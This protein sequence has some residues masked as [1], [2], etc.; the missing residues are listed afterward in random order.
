M[1]KVIVKSLVFLLVFS[2]IYVH[3]AFDL[4]D[5][6]EPYGRQVLIQEIDCSRENGEFMFTDYPKGISK[7]ENIL[8]KPCRV[9]PNNNGGPKYFA[10][11]LGKG[12][13]LTPGKPYILSIEFPDDKP[14]SMFICNWGCETARGFHSG[15]TVG[16][17]IK[18]LYVNHNP[19]SLKIPLS[20]KFQTWSQVFFLHDRFPDIKRPRGLEKRPLLPEDGFWIIIAQ[21]RFENNFESAGA[22]VSKIKL[23]EITD[24]SSLEQKIN[25]PPTELPRR[26][27]FFREEMS[28]GV[29]AQGH[30]ENEKLPE[31]RGINNPINWYEYKLRLMRFLGINTF[32]KD[33]LE[34]GHN[35]GW[36][37]TKYGGND[38]YNQSSTPSLWNDILELIKNKYND[39][40][41]LPYYE[42]A[43]SIG[44]NNNIAIGSQRRCETLRGGK[45]YTHINWCQLTNAD[46]VD[47]DFIEDAKKLLEI[48]IT[49]NKDKVKFIGAWFRPRP[50]ANPISFN[51]KDIEIFNMETGKQISRNDLQNNNG[52]LEEYYNWWFRK[53][54]DFNLALSNYLRKEVNPDAVI[55]YTADSSE[56]GISLPSAVVAKGI[57]NFWEWQTVVVT[58]NTNKW[59]NF[60]NSHQEFFKFVKAI[61]YD[62]VVREDMYLQALLSKPSTWGDYEWHHACPWNDPRNYKEVEG[63]ILTY[64]FNRLYT[65]ASKKALE[66]FKAKS[67]LAIIRHY[68]LNE[69]EMDDNNNPILGYFVADVERAGPYCMI[70]EARA[71]ANGDPRFIGYLSGNSFNRGFPEYVRK[72]NAAFLSLPALPSKIQDNAASDPEVI[73]RIISTPKNG[74]YAGIVNTALV[75]K[76]VSIKLP[77]CKR[78]IDNVSGKNLTLI[79]GKITISMYP[80]ELRS[81]KLE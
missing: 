18:A 33:L 65:V 34:F 28:D 71:F 11:R 70:S 37:S 41:V 6:G 9:L 48:T 56:P 32:S 49:D 17:A 40:Y 51:L 58:D 8:G 69:N 4:T 57:P 77:E 25:Y 19:E 44:Q 38:W 73:L 21:L 16:D 42:Y 50:E 26:H 29:I 7:V 39:L 3:D 63:V 12:L 31:L 23:F 22:A 24:F 5:V 78:V 81:L 14:R 1:N 27:I 79:D 68:G 66:E 13:G 74:I 15:A 67:G 75:E 60:L 35:Q 30:Q 54:R 72:F 45:N 2:I 76:N 46:L 47:P 36:D 55:L 43:G 62:K 61:S 53:R 59:E 20:G 10:Y 64:S 52:L 80:G